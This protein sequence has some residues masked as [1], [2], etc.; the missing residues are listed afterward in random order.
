LNGLLNWHQILSEDSLS[1]VNNWWKFQTNRMTNIGVIEKTVSTGHV[2]AINNQKVCLSV[3]TI[4]FE[5][6]VGS[7]WNL[8]GKCI[9]SNSWM[10]LKMD[11][12]GQQGCQKSWKNMFFYRQFTTGLPECSFLAPIYGAKCLSSKIMR[13][14]F[15]RFSMKITGPWKVL[16]KYCNIS[17]YLFSR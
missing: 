11:K 12:I 5:R 6:S 17:R 3:N 15:Q 14:M 8:A 9:L 10:S 2:C 7:T 4:T 1:L 13:H 16:K